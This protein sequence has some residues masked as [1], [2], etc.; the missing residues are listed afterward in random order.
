MPGRRRDVLIALSLFAFLTYLY[1]LFFSGVSHNPD[2]WFYLAGAQDVVQ[3][4]L[5]GV[6]AHGW[7]F[8]LLL[9]PFYLLSM[10]LPRVGMI[11]VTALLNVLLTALTAS[12][13]F[14]CLNELRYSVRSR[15]FT[16]LA[17]ALATI[18]WR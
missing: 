14:L 13:L 15:L 6:S 16:V 8:A 1:M 4:N 9:T 3:G 10:I 11:Q 5:A 2:E 17:F 12:V 18:A 7:L